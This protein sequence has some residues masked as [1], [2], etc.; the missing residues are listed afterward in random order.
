MLLTV[1][2]DSA[3]EVMRTQHALWPNALSRPEVGLRGD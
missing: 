2:G 1:L 3:A